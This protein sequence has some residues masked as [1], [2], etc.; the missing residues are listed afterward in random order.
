[1]SGIQGSGY[2]DYLSPDPE[3]EE[4]LRPPPPPTSP[5]L[6]YGAGQALGT[7]LQQPGY[8]PPTPEIPAGINS[9]Q[10]GFRGP[11]NP[12]NLQPGPN[13]D[14]GIFDLGKVQEA[15]RIPVYSDLAENVLTPALGS[16][17]NAMNPLGA[18][19]GNEA[20]YN[21]GMIGASA[22]VPVTGFDV[23]L[24][25]ATG[26]GISGFDDL[27]RGAGAL[28]GAADNVVRTA[29]PAPGLV[30]GYGAGVPSG[31]GDMAEYL[32]RQ[33]FAPEDIAS[34]RAN[35]D[36]VPN[37]I[38]EA[39]ES[40]RVAARDA[41][42]NT[43]G[44]PED[45]LNASR[46]AAARAYDNAIGNPRASEANL[47]EEFRIG[48]EIA[49]DDAALARGLWSP[50]NAP[51]PPPGAYPSY[52]EGTMGE[53][54]PWAQDMQDARGG[55]VR[56][57]PIDPNSPAARMGAPLHYDPQY[58]SGTPEYAAREAYESGLTGG[59]AAPPPAP[60]AP[61]ELQQMQFFYDENRRLAGLE[62]GG[63][64]PAPG[65]APSPP[66]SGGPI[67]PASSLSGGAAPP[68]QPPGGGGA[69][70]A[71]MDEPFDSKLDPVRRSLGDTEGGRTL[72]AASNNLQ[73][74]ES[75][76]MRLARDWIARAEAEI[77]VYQ[78]PEGL[79]RLASV[80]EGV[81]NSAGGKYADSFLNE[82]I[83]RRQ[84]LENVLTQSGTAP[85]DLDNR[86]NQ[87]VE[88]MVRQHFPNSSG[89]V[90]DTLAALAKHDASAKAI[91]KDLGGINNVAG[92][93]KSMIYG[94]AD[95]G[96]FG[97]T[98]LAG[99]RNSGPQVV[100][101]MANRLALALHSPLVM[102][103]EQTY[104][105]PRMLVLQNM[106]L[107][108]SGRASLI[109]AGARSPLGLIP[110]LG[111]LDQR[112]LGGAI[113]KLSD[114]QFK[115]VGG[116]LKTMD[117]EGTLALN[118]MWKFLSILPANLARG[119]NPT[120]ALENAKQAATNFILDPKNQREIMTKV[121]ND[122]SS[123]ARAI[124]PGRAQVESSTILSPSFFRSKI[125]RVTD[126]AKLIT[127]GA[128]ETQR[129]MAAQTI[130]A[131]A[132]FILGVYQYLND[133]L[134]IGDAV[135][136]PFAYGFGRITS[137][138]KNSEGQNIIVN[139]VPQNS[140]QNLITQVV[141]AA[142][143][144]DLEA[145]GNA[146][147]R[148]GFGSLNLIPKAAISASG[149]GYDAMGKFYSPLGGERMSLTEA[150]KA[151]IPVPPTVQN[152]IVGKGTDVPSLA[153]QAG[154][155]SSYGESASSAFFRGNDDKR[156]MLLQT[157]IDRDLLL[158]AFPKNPEQ[159]TNLYGLEWKAL[160]YAEQQAII[161]SVKVS[162][163]ER[164]KVLEDAVES[165]KRLNQEKPSAIGNAM[166]IHERTDLAVDAER[167]KIRQ[168]A[169]P[170][171]AFLF[172]GKHDAKEIA[173]VVKGLREVSA[174]NVGREIWKGSTTYTGLPWPGGNE[175]G[176]DPKNAL[177]VA[178]GEWKMIG[179]MA[180]DK[181]GKFNYNSY[182]NM[183]DTYILSLA[184][185]D[186]V[187]AQRLSF[188]E[189]D[190]LARAEASK[191]DIFKFYDWVSDETA[192]YWRQAPGTKAEYLRNHPQ[193][194]ALLNLAGWM[195]ELHSSRAAQLLL[196]MAPNRGVNVA[197]NAR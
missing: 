123:S 152:V 102:S 63:V 77:P 115:G 124:T 147:L 82:V 89:R 195:P 74:V 48:Q 144:G 101:G 4:R 44:S 174:E 178:I 158:A 38:D 40:A 108:L 160:S 96:Y 84:Q 148:Y 100:I 122:W 53:R 156:E 79:G 103:I 117:A 92:A 125:E 32:Q 112:T 21:P 113:E 86:V 31:P 164:A 98:L 72:L 133:K 105:L 66:A 35:N 93:F 155:F 120:A 157:L 64:G 197:K 45:Q 10:A 43:P 26:G 166:A 69:S 97:Q 128:S 159:A 87:M 62:A 25:L 56:E 149:Y 6:G 61:T 151:N 67:P 116:F 179:D 28:R 60:S 132:V 173:G 54:F 1:M 99:V 134:G 150:G 52:P 70:G 9:T 76:S 106:G 13:A 15:T 8:G 137:P 118:Y 58:I 153:I 90:T 182:E 186:P 110:G 104:D 190:R 176:N 139:L 191:P 138:L 75:D 78:T 109:D 175:P 29:M 146:A 119:A 41:Y 27:A 36:I 130:A 181:D 183:K 2:F 33:G 131:Q 30:P 22:L 17:L 192:E 5:P 23:G 42:M 188:Y 50:T 196:D 37:G 193:T 80:I 168:A 169:E 73:A 161:N 46:A 135:I 142:Q 19:I 172:D 184:A 180:R 121:N 140:F 127:P 129:I 3:E 143:K 83:T 107:D 94:M 68:I 187:T 167:E 163:P 154:G 20:G 91:A 47:A 170:L 16:A 177:D 57:V 59:G 114:A 55:G 18:A 24:N 194:D 14:M 49:G 165:G 34:F 88:G 81:T 12:A 95:V 85:R 185:K 71:P 145:A 136:D 39:A 51:A 189:A 65:N 141:D 126:L 7:G 162:D 11:E 111:G 171:K